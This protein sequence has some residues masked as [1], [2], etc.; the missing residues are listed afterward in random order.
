MKQYL[1]QFVAVIVAVVGKLGYAGIIFMMFLESSFFPFPS[2]VVI[3]PAGYLASRGEMHFGLV[4][5]AGITGSILGAL[6][7]YWLAVV[8][9]RPAIL[10]YGRFV[11]LTPPRFARVERYFT[12][13]G[14]IS[15]FIGRLLPGIRQYIS[16]PA[17]LTRMKLLPFVVFTGLGAGIWVVILAVIGYYV[18]NNEELIRRYAHQAF[19]F[20][21]PF[22]L[23]VTAIY[24]HR[25]RRQRQKNAAN[26]L[27]Q[28]PGKEK[29]IRHP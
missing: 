11:G 1:Y 2:E 12:D 14:H 13:H 3:P 5:A 28:A 20:L 8:L 18:G 16:F 27:C 21:I 9:G 6:F 15:T 4:I 22:L 19:Y 7:N 29:N 23:V 10:R 24:I 17:G 26:T 25:H